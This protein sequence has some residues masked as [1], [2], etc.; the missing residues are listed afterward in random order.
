MNDGF[1]WARDRR[2]ELATLGSASASGSSNSGSSNSGSAL[3]FRFHRLQFIDYLVNQKQDEALA[4]ARTHFGQF[5][6]TQMS[7]IQH[8]MGSF[9]YAKR[10]SKSPYA[11]LFHPEHMPALWD[12]ILIIYLL[13]VFLFLYIYSLLF[14]L[15]IYY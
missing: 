9:V 10:L 6:S 12:G 2:R 7:E 4:Y 13:L 11:G 1:S 3:E 15:L 14:G 8:L 5:A